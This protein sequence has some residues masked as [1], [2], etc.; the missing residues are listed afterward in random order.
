LA[1]FIISGTAEPLVIW[2]VERQT[3]TVAIVDSSKM[4]V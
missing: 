4:L 2:P 3:A 1:G